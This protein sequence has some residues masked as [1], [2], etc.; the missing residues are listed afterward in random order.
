MSLDHPLLIGLFTFLATLGGKYI[1]DRWLKQSS[2]VTFLLCDQKRKACVAELSKTLEAKITKIATTVE[3]QAERL[4][5]GDH[6]FDDI[7]ENQEKMAEILKV[8]LLTLL[9]LCESTDGC[10]EDTKKQLKDGIKSL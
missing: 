10:C 8:I 9:E 7:K 4:K 2:R 6:C 3:N 1:W 5:G